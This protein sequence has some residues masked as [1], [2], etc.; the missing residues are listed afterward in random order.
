VAIGT[1]RTQVAAIHLLKPTKELL[2]LDRTDALSVLSANADHAQD[3][4]A[5]ET[6]HT[7]VHFPFAIGDTTRLSLL[8]LQLTLTQQAR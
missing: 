3:A 1:T 7:T 2:I 4:L 6:L 5:A 8:Y